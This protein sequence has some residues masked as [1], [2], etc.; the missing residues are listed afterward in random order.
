[1]L[2][3]ISLFWIQCSSS[4]NG[5]KLGNNNVMMTVDRIKPTGS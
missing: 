5:T 4:V 1:M 3:A 2:V